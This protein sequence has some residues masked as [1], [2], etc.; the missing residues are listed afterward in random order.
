MTYK[1]FVQWPTEC[2]P[3]NGGISDD[4]AHSLQAAQGVCDLLKENGFG[5]DGEFYPIRTWIE[6]Y[7][8]GKKVFTTEK[9]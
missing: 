4:S 7:E 5:G 6:G 9:K 3:Y 8:N 1:S 2:Y